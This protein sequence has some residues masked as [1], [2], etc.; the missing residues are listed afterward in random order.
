[1]PPLPRLNLPLKR[2][3]NLRPIVPIQPLPLLRQLQFQG[4]Q[5]QPS[6]FRQRQQPDSLA[7]LPPNTVQRCIIQPLLFHRYPRYHF[8]DPC[9]VAPKPAAAPTAAGFFVPS[10]NHSIPRNRAA[11]RVPHHHR[12]HQLRPHPSG[13]L[14]AQV[15]GL[16]NSS[17]PCQKFHLPFTASKQ[18]RHFPFHQQICRRVWFRLRHCLHLVYCREL[19]PPAFG[20]T[21]IR[22]KETARSSALLESG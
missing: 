17:V 16:R 13:A 9:F 8:T 10:L 11:G 5:G 15:S 3:D 21:D 14:L 20:P 22:R 19:F 4:P 6:L 2:R 12:R 18:G 7:P 1:L